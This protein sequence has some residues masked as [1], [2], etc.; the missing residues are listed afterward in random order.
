MAIG[1]LA[2]PETATYSDYG[3]AASGPT[4]LLRRFL[5]HAF[6][7]ARRENYRRIARIVSAATSISRL[8]TSPR[9]TRSGLAGCRRRP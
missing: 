5:Q 8:S 1:L 2:T 3:R 9:S 4:A 6:A 7:R